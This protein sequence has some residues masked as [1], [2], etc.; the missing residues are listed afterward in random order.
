MGVLWKEIA[1]ML[2]M[3]K[4]GNGRIFGR[5]NGTGNRGMKVRIN[6]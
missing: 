2:E 5:E 1:G 3:G 4:R 6:N